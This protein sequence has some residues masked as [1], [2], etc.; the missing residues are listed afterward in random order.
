MDQARAFREQ[1]ALAFS[2]AKTEKAEDRQSMIELANIWLKSAEKIERQRRTAAL[3]D[4]WY[5]K[6]SVLAGGISASSH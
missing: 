4:R 1:A 3:V 6:L 2:V 5:Q